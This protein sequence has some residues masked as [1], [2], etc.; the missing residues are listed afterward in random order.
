MS[1]QIKNGIVYSKAGIPVSSLRFCDGRLSFAYD[2]QGVSRL[3]YFLPNHNQFNTKLFQRG[4]FDCFR[5]FVLRNGIRYAPQYKNVEVYPY[6]LTADWFVG[7]DRLK[8]GVYALNENLYFSLEGGGDFKFGLSFYTST[9]YIPAY[10]GDFD[11]YE[12]ESKRTWKNWIEMNNCLYGGLNETKTNFDFKIGIVSNQPIQFKRS[13]VNSRFDGIVKCSNQTYF[14][15]VFEKK[16]TEFS[17]ELSMAQSNFGELLDE[18]KRRYKNVLSR[19]P[20]LKTEERKVDTFFSLAPLYHESLKPKDVKGCVRAH[21]TRY[22]VWGWD[23]MIANNASFIWNDSKYVA[24]MLKFFE[25]TADPVKGIMHSCS[26]DNTA[27][28][29]AVTASQ[30]IYITLAELYWQHTGDDKRIK[31]LYPFIKHIFEKIT[32]DESQIKGLFTGT[33]LFPDF[34]KFLQETGRD[35]SLFNNTVSYVALRAMETLAVLVG[36]EETANKARLLYLNT[37]TNFFDS[38]YDIEKGYFVNSVDADTFKKRNSYNICGYFWD[39]EYHYDL[40]LSKLKDCVQFIL[41]NGISKNGFKT[42]PIWDKAYDADGNQLHCTWPAVE[43]VILRCLQNAQCAKEIQ[44][45]MQQIRDWTAKLTCPEGVSYLYETDELESD[46]W[47]CELGI[48]QAYSVRKRYE[49]ILGIVCGLSLDCGGLTFV[50]PQTPFEL[51]NFWV[52]GHKTRIKTEGTGR[53]LEYIDINGKKIYNS[54]K[55]PLDLISKTSTTKIT[56]MLGLNE[57]IGLIRAVG[58]KIFNYIERKEGI[59]FNAQA[60][61]RKILHFNKAKSVFVNGKS[62]AI[63]ENKVSVY[64]EKNK[65]Y[66][67]EVVL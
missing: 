12:F 17:Q 52:L 59:L 44:I 29:F 9:Q 33:S 31:Q 42:I 22:W 54:K 8:F 34:P 30:G 6:G 66:T 60:L 5:C 26:Y 67:F 27:G 28:S 48:W 24:D 49:E 35:I 20:K 47:N 4:I 63:Q 56:L 61:G 19:S 32:T 57:S 40:L 45:W 46:R 55:I 53:E 37:E 11:S 23:T 38:F 25:N 21:T 7:D 64:F 13:G 15:V 10:N 43:E 51:K 62:I 14:A 58:V 36:D 50:A 39:S 18:Q 2:E 16:N 65:V 3:D 41:D 1:Q